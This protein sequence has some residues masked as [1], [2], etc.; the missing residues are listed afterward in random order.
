MA[1]KKVLKGE[2]IALDAELCLDYDIKPGDIIGIE[3]TGDGFRVVPL[4]IKRRK[5]CQ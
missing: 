3:D 1:V 2:R 5:I 4:D